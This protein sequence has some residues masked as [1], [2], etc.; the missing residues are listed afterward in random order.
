MREEWICILLQICNPILDGFITKSI[1]DTFPKSY[2]I[3]S[4]KKHYNENK[5]FVELFCRTLMSIS[6]LFQSKEFVEKHHYEELLQKTIQCIQSGFSLD[7]DSKLYLDYKNMGD[8]VIVEMANLAIAFLRTPYLWTQIDNITKNKI[9]EAMKFAYNYVFQH[10]N[11]WILFKCI[12]G[13]FLYK[14]KWLNDLLPVYFFLQH[15]ETYYIGDGWYKDGPSFHMDYYNSFV[16]LPFL[17]T[18]YKELQFINHNYTKYYESTL[19]KIERHSE[20]L[21]RLISE[22]GTFP[23]FGRSAVYRTAIFHA[24][25]YTVYL[26]QLPKSLSYGQVREALNAVIKRMYITSRDHILDEHNYLKLGFS[27]YQPNMANPYSNSGSVYF[28]LLIFLPLGL[29]KDHP[30]WTSTSEDWSQK[31]LWNYQSIPID[32]YL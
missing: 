11:N 13:I 24:L 7:T 6:T 19:K 4:H 12:I 16:I 20:F 17:V 32:E 29:D 26:D 25:S 8:Q 15:F 22:N 5:I 27:E 2:S 31:K 3:Y 28:A 21:E 30:F 9:R 14:N 10:Q 23:I 1:K 18:I